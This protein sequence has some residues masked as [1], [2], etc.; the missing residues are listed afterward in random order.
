M[1]LSEMRAARERGESQSALEAGRSRTT[2]RHRAWQAAAGNRPGTHH[3]DWIGK[4]SYWPIYNLDLKN[5][6]P[7]PAL[8]TPTPR[9]W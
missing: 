3:G 6:T 9:T 4:E 7:R 2:G 8:N 5:P 1:T